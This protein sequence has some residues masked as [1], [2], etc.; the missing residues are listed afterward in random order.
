MGSPSFCQMYHPL[1]RPLFAPQGLKVRGQTLSLGTLGAHAP[2]HSST[3]TL[4]QAC[5][6]VSWCSPASL[7]SSPEPGPASQALQP[8]QPAP[9]PSPR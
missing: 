1:S 4:G 2:P 9:S 7:S 5:L 6:G 8:A 3:V